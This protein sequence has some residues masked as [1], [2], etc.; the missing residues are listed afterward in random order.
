MYAINSLISSL[1][2]NISVLHTQNVIWK[3][4][5]FPSFFF[6]LQLTDCWIDKILIL[7]TKILFMGY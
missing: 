2:R 1:N 3:R 7:A 5:G 6:V 4:F